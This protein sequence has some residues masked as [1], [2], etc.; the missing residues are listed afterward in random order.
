MLNAFSPQDFSTRSVIYCN[1]VHM[2]E[3]YLIAV[4]PDLRK[5]YERQKK[6]AE[7][8]WLFR[9]IVERHAHIGGPRSEYQLI[10]PKIKWAAEPDT[11]GYFSLLG[12]RGKP[13]FGDAT[14]TGAAE[15]IRQVGSAELLLSEGYHRP[16]LSLDIIRGI[17]TDY[18]GQDLTIDQLNGFTTDLQR[19]EQ[20][21]IDGTAPPT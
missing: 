17:C 8:A 19:Y 5:A 2:T 15:L 1:M 3:S 9:G 16:V 4:T 11:V 7:V 14:Q 12:Y 20:T 18:T 13:L 21:I 10:L 6:T